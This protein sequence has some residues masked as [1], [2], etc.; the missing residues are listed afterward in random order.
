MISGV[1]GSSGYYPTYSSSSTSAKASDTSFQ[2]KLLT[3]LDTDG[4]GKVSS[5]EVDSAL[6]SAQQSGDNGK[7]G[8]LVSLSQN[9]SGLDSDA[10]DSLDLDELAAMAPPPPPPGQTSVED[11]FASLDS[12][13][14][15]EISSDELT[16]AL[17]SSSTSSD[18]ASELLSSLDSDDDGSVSESELAAAMMP[19]PPP[20][21]D[22]T[23]TQAKSSDDSAQAASGVANGQSEEQLAAQVLQRMIANLSKQYGT[24]GSVSGGTVSTAA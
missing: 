22:G 24:A 20:P 11:L 7:A 6:S 3:E 23:S 21:S 2:K 9:F 5:S 4:D 17:S 8:V 14:D 15:G 1:S 19:P 12:D 13:S 18:Q 16:S 10:D